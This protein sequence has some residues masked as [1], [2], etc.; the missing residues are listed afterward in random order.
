[1]ADAIW[2]TRLM[3]ADLELGDPEGH[4]RI[5]TQASG[6]NHYASADG[7]GYERYSKVPSFLVCVTFVYEKQ[8]RV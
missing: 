4:S 8:A 3:V 1:M 7:F 5:L 2:R 6:D